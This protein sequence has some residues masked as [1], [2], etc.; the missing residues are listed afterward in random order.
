MKGRKGNLQ[1]AK[2]KRSASQG[3]AFDS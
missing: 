1:R 2:E 3:E